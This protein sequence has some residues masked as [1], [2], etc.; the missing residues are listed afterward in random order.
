MRVTKFWARGYRSL[1]DV[2]LPDLGPFVILYGPNGS[3]KSNLLDAVHTFFRL[4]P[5]AVDTAFGDDEVR[6]SFWDAGREASKWIRLDEFFGREATDEIVLGAVLELP[7]SGPSEPRIEVEITFWRPREDQFNLKISRLFIDGEPRALPF[8]DESAR[9]LLQSIV[10]KAFTHLGVTRSLSTS[11]SDGIRP[12]RLIGTILDSELVNEL[13]LAKNS[14]EREVRDRFYRVQQFIETT[15]GHKIDVYVNEAKQLE[16]REM[17][18]DPNPL[19]V[20]IRAEHA[21]HGLIQMYAI[22]ASILL[23]EGWLVALEEPEAHL[24]APTMGRKLR[25]ILYDMVVKDELIGQ[26]FIATHS[27]LFDLDETG[28]WDVAL[29]NGETVVRRKPLDE[30]DRAH[31]YEPGPAKHQLQ[32]VLRLYGN[33]IVFHT[34]DGRSLTAEQ[35]LASLQN[36]DDVAQ[37]FLESMH[38]VALQATGLRAMRERSDA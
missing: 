20:E 26:L 30:I 12:A 37:A 17:L 33:D 25:S 27:N 8:F 1:K 32:E 38:A 18:P 34:A 16:L 36:D 28:Y 21:G 35:M 19:G 9:D 7:D 29:E 11:G 15:I 4:M 22:L 31:L 6:R 3:G 5:L 14:H 2:V 13:F 24:H 10:P 23:A